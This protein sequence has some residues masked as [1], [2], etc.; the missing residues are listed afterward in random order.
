MT[1]L[2]K[3]QL[4]QAL[5]PHYRSAAQAEKAMLLD[6]FTKATG[7][8]RK[9]AITLLRQGRS[10]P[11]RPR[12]PGRSRYD[13]QTVE[14]LRRLWEASGSLCSKKRLRPFLAPLLEALARCGERT[15]APGVK[16]ALLRM[17]PAT[18]DR[19][20][21]PSRRRL[22]PR[23][24]TT[25]R[26]GSLLKRQIPVR[27][28]AQWD[29]QRPGFTEMDLVAHCGESTHGESVQSLSG[30]AIATGWFEARAV[31]NRSQRRVF[32]ALP[33][34]RERL[35]FPLCGLDADHDSA[36]IN[37]HLIASCRTHRLTFT[38]SREYRKN[39][40]AHVE[41]RNGALI[42][43]LI[44]SDRYE[45]EPATAAFN[46]ASDVLQR[47]I[48]VFQPTM[49]L[50]AKERGGAKVIKRYDQAKTPYQR[51]LD[52]PDVSDDRKQ[53]LREA[54]QTLN[55]IAIRGELHHRLERLWAFALRSDS[56]MR[57]R[58]VESQVSR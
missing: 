11:L 32:A 50:V 36:F 30:V 54:Y 7:Y 17:S 5:H 28:F 19:K 15:L 13:G 41:E 9:Y 57:Q 12:R 1:P 38:R 37:A 18:I 10:S 52:A 29:E 16:A 45:G 35:P 24:R 25:T 26:P 53:A 58:L 3:R 43:R 46:T 6:A 8:H 4:L 2:V 14:A 51:L 48:N 31:V 22:K 39:D 40:Q 33:A 49:R 20:L 23:G 27:T 47:W 21:A 56:S 42:R 34:L 44:G 55:P